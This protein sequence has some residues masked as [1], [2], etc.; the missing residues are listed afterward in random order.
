[1]RFL[2]SLALA[3][4]LPLLA[5]ACVFSHTRTPLDTDLSVTRL[6]SKTGTSTARSILWLVA[7]GDAS[8]AAAA[9]DG[10]I[11]VLNHMDSEQLFIL[12]GVYA[13]YTTIVHGD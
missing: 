12:F 11:E 8:S 1:M 4:S 10:G 7:W 3:L 13:S 5:G 2:R 9:K 6:G